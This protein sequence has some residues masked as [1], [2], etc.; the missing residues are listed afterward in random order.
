MIL[1]TLISQKKNGRRSDEHTKISFNRGDSG[2]TNSF[3]RTT[4]K[5]IKGR[6]GSSIAV[7][8]GLA[9]V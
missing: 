8:K 2:S 4:P 9:G 7:Y 1:N 3:N 5:S 6:P